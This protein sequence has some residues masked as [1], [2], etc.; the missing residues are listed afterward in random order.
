MAEKVTRAQRAARGVLFVHS[1]P[2]ALCP[3][4][5]WAAGRALGTPV[6]FGRPVASAD[7]GSKTPLS[8]TTQPSSVKVI[9][10]GEFQLVSSSSGHSFWPR[11]WPTFLS[12][13]VGSSSEETWMLL[14]PA[15][16][17]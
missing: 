2:R 8:S 14:P 4:V 7:S 6:N 16:D 10:L 11:V 15:W 13:P 12:L 1:S 5:E 9:P 17:D 3:H